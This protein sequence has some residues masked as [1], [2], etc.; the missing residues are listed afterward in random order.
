[1]ANTCINLRA[2]SLPITE[3]AGGFYVL[4]FFGDLY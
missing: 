1:M 4:F 3:F 2:F